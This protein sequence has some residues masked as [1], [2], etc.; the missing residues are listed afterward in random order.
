[1]KTPPAI[2]ASHRRQAEVFV[3]IAEENPGI[4]IEQLL[5]LVKEETRKDW[6]ECL[7]G[8][9]PDRFRKPG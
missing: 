1:M 3:R 7:H 8:E 2:E 6:Q 4:K 5:E 9:R